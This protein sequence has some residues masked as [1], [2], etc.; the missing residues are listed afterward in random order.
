MRAL[1]SGYY[2]YGNLGD[3]A[4]LGALTAGLTARGVEPV[5][6]SGR[7]ESTRSLHHVPAAHRYRGLLPA[8]LRADVLVSG[9]GGLLQDRSS[10]RSLSYYLFVLRLARQLGRRPIVYGQSV[11]PLSDDGRRKVGRALRGLPVAVRDAPSAALL[12][13]LGLAPER[14]A[15]PALLLEPPRARSGGAVLL[16]PRSGHGA[17]NA[18]LLTAGRALQ[19]RGIAVALLG[20][21]EAEDDEV[22]AD[23]EAALG[24]RRWKASTP[25]EAVQR[26][27]ASDYVL[28]ARLHGLI[29][30]AV[31]GIGFAGLVY[32]PKVAGFL[33]EAAAPAFHEPVDGERLVELAMQRPP[34]Q[35]AAIR[36]L[37]QR[38]EAGL[39]WLALHIRR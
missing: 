18:A 34:P 38:A 26:V 2:G 10:H 1:L 37:R 23:L 5:V 7:P 12:E 33:D 25:A 31:A 39:D 32:D 28:S 4:L 15:D 11:G 19:A 8:L 9:G 21:H 30:A 17:L 24:V 22:L 35:E 13:G 16:I 6:L 3:E 36:R 20:L 27:A 14:V 29:F